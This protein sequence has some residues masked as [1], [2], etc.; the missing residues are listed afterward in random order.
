MSELYPLWLPRIGAG[1]L[2]FCF[3]LPGCAP[4]TTSAHD[5]PNAATSVSADVL[6]PG[7]LHRAIPTRDGAG[8]DLVD[9]DLAKSNCRLTI[10]TRG[11]VMANGH[12]VGQAYT[13]HEWLTRTHGLMAVNGGYFGADDPAGRKEFVGLLVQRRRVRHAAPPLLG[14]GSATIR[15]GQYV[16]SAFG[17]MSDG[18]PSIAWAATD[19]GH[20]QTLNTYAGPMSRTC[21]EWP[22]AE[23][24]GCGPT[25]I[26]NGRIDVTQY[27]E[28]LVSPGP[29]PRTF[30]AYD[31]PPGR[32]Q[33]LIVGIA[34]GADF[35]E[36]AA[37]VSRYF[38][39]YDS[40]RAQA[41]MCVD[42]GAS[43]QMTYTAGGVVQSPR[44][45]GVTVPD[46]LV[47]LPK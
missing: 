46:A 22:I 4:R 36:L 8:I 9:I 34:S 1:G 43:T 45:T 38:P 33:H 39:K 12:I 27:Q 21:T 5:V 35:Q 26:S 37:F 44:E 2:F 17:L 41:A 20:P 25:L 10:Q 47:L 30:V 11:I 28:R 24:V 6:A 40:S 19:P 3:L 14:S 16:R 32:P 13:P 31:G 29:E 42:G 18:T 7:V 15:R 23:A